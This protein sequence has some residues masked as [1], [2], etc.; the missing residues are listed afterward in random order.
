MGYR[1]LYFRVDIIIALYEHKKTLDMQ[2]V[3]AKKYIYLFISAS[4]CFIKAKDS[5]H[6]VFVSTIK[7]NWLKYI[8]N[9]KQK[10]KDKQIARNT[11]MKIVLKN[12][13][14]IELNY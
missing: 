3:F 11:F 14:T 4:Y 12:Y 9:T 1:A 6:L 5:K 10:Y 7:N 13:I 8:N 2:F